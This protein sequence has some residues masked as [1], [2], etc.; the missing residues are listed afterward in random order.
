MMFSYL[1][2]DNAINNIKIII[3]KCDR[4]VTNMTFPFDMLHKRHITYIEEVYLKEYR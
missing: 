4:G 1:R 3:S 2:K